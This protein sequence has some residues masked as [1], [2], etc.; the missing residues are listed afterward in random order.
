LL[1]SCAPAPLVMGVLD[2][3]TVGGTAQSAEPH[4]C[5]LQRRASVPVTMVGLPMVPATINGRPARLILDTGAESSIINGA[6]AKRLGV[7]SKYDFAR[8]MRGIGEAV[9]TGDARLDSMTLGSAT[10]NFPRVL[11]GRIALNLGGV[12]PDG[13]LGASLLADFDLDIDL[14][15]R[16]L[17]LYERMDC[18]SFTPPWS[19]R[20]TTLETTRSLSSHPFFPIGLNGR[21]ISASVD[22]GAQRTVLSAAGAKRAGIGAGTRLPGTEV[23]AQGAAG[24]TLPAEMHVLQLRVGDISGR[25]PVM[26]TPLALPNDID[27]LLGADFLQTHRI[28][29]S[30]GSR[31]LFVAS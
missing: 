12:E 6:A 8:S 2:P 4:N 21:T 15:N 18:P 27:A 31:R 26:V 25:M 17:E 24:E 3:E 5:T 28:W 13:L 9:Q 23:R 10:L 7:T 16:R 29:L 20:F 14:P 1:T 11:V 19:G 22:T 30:Y